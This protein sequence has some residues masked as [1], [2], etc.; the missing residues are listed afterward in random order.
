MQQW[1]MNNVQVLFPAPYFPG[2]LMDVAK[3]DHE[4]C[5][6][7]SC[8]FNSGREGQGEGGGWAVQQI[9]K[10]RAQGK[11]ASSCLQIN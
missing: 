4:G 1:T 7:L 2:G 8:H 3:K 11:E 6:C 5:R 10:G 9:I